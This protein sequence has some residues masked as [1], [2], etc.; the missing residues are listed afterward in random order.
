MFKI[1]IK[2]LILTVVVA[3]VG[4]ISDF[5]LDLDKPYMYTVGFVVGFISSY[6]LS[7]LVD[8]LSKIM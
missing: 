2:I 6:P 7:K 4:S 3:M 1:I 8:D 5:L